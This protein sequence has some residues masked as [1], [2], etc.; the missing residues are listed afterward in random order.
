MGQPLVLFGGTVIDPFTGYCQP[1]SVLI[2]NSKIEAMEGRG[3]ALPTNYKEIDCRGKLVCPGLIDVHV[4][5]RTPGQTHKETLGSLGLA[6]IAGGFTTIVCM[7]NT[8]PAIDTVEILNANLLEMEQFSF[9]DMFQVSAVTQKRQGEK[10]LPFHKLAAQGAIAFSDDGDGI[11]DPF[12]LFQAMSSVYSHCRPIFLHCQDKR[13]DPYDRRAEIHDVSLA[14]RISEAHNLPVHLQ[15]ISCKESVQLIREAKKRGVPVTCE[16]APH[17]FSLTSRDFKRIGANAKMNPPLRSESD[18][19]AVIEGLKDGTIDIIATDHAPHS[20]EE[21]A[22]NVDDAP[23]GVIGLETAVPVFFTSLQN[24]LEIADSKLTKMIAKMTLVP[25]NLLGLEQK[26]RI[27]TGL[28]ADLVV[29]DSKK[30]Q[31]VKPE[32]FQSKARNCPW[33]GKRLKGWPVMTIKD[34]QVVMQEGKITI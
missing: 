9:V 16:T 8:N 17:Y 34:G 11:Q 5:G 27:Q 13:F 33:A 12:I 3:R 26:G 29:I 30:T 18:R 7:A 14:L 24:H 32:N 20:P 15:H 25:A 6:A 22:A 4:H 21:K 10:L 28:P 31:H 23:F 19:Q 2:N 1:G